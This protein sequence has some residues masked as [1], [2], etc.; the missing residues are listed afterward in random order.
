MTDE[1]NQ[2]V[3]G[4]AR[5]RWGGAFW[6]VKVPACLL[7]IGTIVFA[8]TGADLALSGWFYL[9]GAGVAGGT[10]ADTPF[11][12]FVY[13]RGTLLAAALAWAGVGVLLASPW[14]VAARRWRKIAA[15]FVLVVAI[16]P[17]LLVNAVFKDHWGRPRPRDV[18]DFGGKERFERVWHFDPASPGKSFPSGHA[19]MGFCLFALFFIGRALGKPWAWW[20]L[21]LALTLGIALGITRIAQGGHF[22]SDVLWSAGICYFTALVLARVMGLD[23]LPRPMVMG[24]EETGDP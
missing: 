13:H 19:S 24:C 11:F 12:S 20:A 5:G 6:L 9:P 18:A 23:S 8:M 16:A 3:D 21:A 7:A 15:Y 4:G 17:G 10:W 1:A 2:H 22:A 14:W